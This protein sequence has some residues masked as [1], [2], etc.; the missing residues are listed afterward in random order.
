MFILPQDHSERV[1]QLKEHIVYN[2]NHEKNV[3]SL[4]LLKEAHIYCVLRK[5]SSQQYG[6]LLE[7]YI[8]TKF[9]YIK[10]DAKDSIGDCAKNGKNLEIKVSLGGASHS[11]FNF[12]QIRPSHNCDS[13]ILTAYHLN[14]ENVEEEGE[15]FI[16]KVSKEDMKKII[17]SYGGYAHGTIKNNGS[18]TMESLNDK[19]NNLE[20]AIRPSVND[21]CWQTLMS[22]RI[23]ENDL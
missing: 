2:V 7:K 6:P 21:K 5:L 16:F 11:K 14:F 19:E 1:K 15:L 10:N 3:M 13:Y 12:V 8:R 22:H 9:D 17:I 20:Y 18:I 4:T 23:Y